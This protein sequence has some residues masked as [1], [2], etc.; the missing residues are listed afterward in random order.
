VQFLRNAMCCCK[1]LHLF[2]DTVLHESKHTA[3]LYDFPEPMNKTTPLEL[4]ICVTQ[5]YAF[6]S[7]T[8]SGYRLIMKSGYGKLRRINQLQLIN[9][10][11]H[12]KSTTLPERIV[13]ERLVEE[14]QAAR[15]SIFIGINVFF[16]GGS[17]FWLFANSLHV[18]ETDWI[19]GLPG[20]IHA[21]TVMEVCLVPLLYFMMEDGFGQLAKSKRMKKLVAVLRRGDR[22]PDDA[23]NAEAYSWIVADGY[24][25]GWNPFWVHEFDALLDPLPDEVSETKKLNDEIT[26]LNTTLEAIT[27][28]TKGT[29]NKDQESALSLALEKTAAHLEEEVPVLRM[30]GYREFFYFVLNFIAF[31]GYLLGVVVFY[32]DKEDFQPTYVREL[33]FRMTNAD[34]DWHGNFAGDLMWTIEP[35]VILGSP[36]LMGW[37]KSKIAKV[38]TD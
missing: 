7:T 9:S 29:V 22:V 25:N 17:F 34:A 38:K 11:L 12:T 3:L 36:M 8:L 27:G 37:T 10:K 4:L 21:L 32:Y 30:E 1:D 35:I 28:K 23:L 5:L 16:I 6:V 2:G 20:L 24:P 26:M 33:K 18:T 31:Y 14:R 19:G 13:N 15:R